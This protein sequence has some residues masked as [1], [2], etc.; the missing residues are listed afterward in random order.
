MGKLNYK[1][2]G[3]TLYEKVNMNVVTMLKGIKLNDFELLFNSSTSKRHND[4]DIKKEYTKVKKY[5]HEIG[6]NSNNRVEYNH[7]NGKYGRLIAKKGKPCI[8]RLYNGIRGVLCNDNMI[9][10]DMSNC[11]IVLLIN[12]CKENKFN[13]TEYF[14]LSEYNNNREEVLLNLMNE[15]GISRGIAKSSFL[16]CI[17][18]DFKHKRIDGDKYINKD[19]F[20]ERFDNETTN[21]INKLT[22][23]YKNIK[24]YIDSYNKIL[25]DEKF[26]I[27]GKFINNILCKYENEYLWKALDGLIHNNIIKPEDVAVLMLDG[28][29]FYKNDDT[30]IERL[31]LFLNDLFKT[32]NMKWTNKEHNIELLPIIKTLYEQK[33]NKKKNKSNSNILD[34]ID[35]YFKELNLSSHHYYASEFLKEI[36]QYKYIYNNDE[37]YEYNDNNILK[38]IGK[39][40]PLNLSE[41][42]T[43][44]LNKKLKRQM[45]KMINNIEP[46][47]IKFKKYNDIYKVNHKNLGNS[48]YKEGI[49]TE[50]KIHFSDDDLIKKINHNMAV[51]SFND[52]LFDF[53]LKDFR[54]I[55]KND[56][57][58][59]YCDYPAPC[60]KNEKIN[61]ELKNILFSIF[62]DDE[63][64]QFF[65]DSIGYSLFTNKFEKL[66]MWSGSGGNGKGLLMKLLVKSFG[67]YFNI[68]NNQFL[69]TKYDGARANSSLF[70]T[71]YKK[72]VMVSEPESDHSGDI[73]FNIEFIKKLTG[74]D[75]ITTRDLFKSDVT[76]TPTFTT[77][78]QCND[79][80]KLD[81]MDDAVKRRFLCLEFPFKFTEK[82]I[83][84]TD[85]II[86]YSLKDKLE[87]INYYSQF[88]LLLIENIKDKIDKN[89][90]IPQKIK[91]NTI[92]YLNEN[93]V[94]G[95]FIEE[96]LEITD[97]NKDKM[98]ITKLYKLFKMDNDDN[99]FTQSKFKSNLINNGLKEKTIRGTKAFFG[100][101]E[102]SFFNEDSDDDNIILNGDSGFC[103]L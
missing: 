25:N 37:W 70:N 87:D 86:D 52:K 95:A 26:N 15:H 12:L 30:D 41:N 1:K 66:H 98:N 97:D 84:D 51:V 45:T 75:E 13:Q 67:N 54:D 50:L 29:M 58:C 31:L 62:E 90:F 6:I 57:I 42:I 93:N 69:T 43:N 7:V 49:I 24:Q 76:F 28:F 17:N 46:H 4:Y 56:Y 14:C 68:P 89:L 33:K 44:V 47:D 99:F 11:H 40:P 18:S 74:R 39:K 2:S 61:L 23:I 53:K 92:N 91:D 10:I 77:F 5:I 34:E 36:D 3:V 65:M 64:I 103:D 81:K 55:E 38:L 27:N 102:K 73:L 79:K 35:D 82:K 16:C 85:R 9:D 20:F 59:L 96:K 32:N 19:S 83:K 21:I 78:V 101:K 80:P 48:K 94:V 22:K 100:I 71:Q 8:Q 63:I 60:I 72:I 88:M